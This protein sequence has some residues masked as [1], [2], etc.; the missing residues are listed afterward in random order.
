MCAGMSVE[1]RRLAGV[2]TILA[3]KPRDMEGVI[4]WGYF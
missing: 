3:E 4:Y 2:V 1:W